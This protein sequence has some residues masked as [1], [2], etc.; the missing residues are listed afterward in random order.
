MS[1]ISGSFVQDFATRVPTVDVASALSPLANRIPGSQASGSSQ[2]APILT[3]APRAQKS[4]Q[5]KYTGYMAELANQYDERIVNA[6]VS[7]DSQRVSQGQNPLSEE[8]T[9]RALQTAQTG[10]AATQEASPSPFNL[11]GNAIRNIGDIVRSIPRIPSALVGEARDLSKIGESIEAGKNPISG[12]ASAP[13][14]RMLPGAYLVENLAE[15]DI[16]ELVSNPIFTALDVLPMGSQLAKSTKVATAAREGAQAVARGGESA[17]RVVGKTAG[18]EARRLA[19]MERRPLA[20]AL[21]N[22]LDADGNIVRTASGNVVDAITQSRMVRPLEKWFSQTQRD[23]M[24]EVNAAQQRVHNIVTGVQQAGDLG[25]PSGQLDSISRDAAKL[26]EDIIALDPTI[27][28]RIPEITQKMVEGK[29]NELTGI[30]AQAAQLYKSVM[31][32]TTE[33]SVANNYHVMFDG[34]VYDINSGLPLIKQ[35]RRMERTQRLNDLRNQTI[36][37]SANPADALKLLRETYA[38]ERMTPTAIGDDTIAK[39]TRAQQQTRAA[40]GNVVSGGELLGTRR[41]TLRALESSGYDTSAFYDV[42]KNSKGRPTKKMKADD[43]LIRVVDDVIEGRVTLEKK[44]LLNRDEILQV[45]SANEGTYK[46]NAL[47][48]LKAGLEKGEYKVVT[49]A[50]ETLKKQKGSAALSDPVFLDSIRQLRDTQREL[51]KTRR[52]YSDEAVAK[53]SKNLAEKQSVTPSARF[54]PE[55]DKRTRATVTEQLVD[56]LGANQRLIPG[57]DVL[58]AAQVIELADRGMWS[59]IPGWT[60]EM[61]RKIQREQVATWQDMKARGFDPMFIHTVPSNRIGRVLHPGESIVPN[62]PSST[63]AR[64]WDLAP[65]FKDFTIAATDQMIEYLRRRETEVAIKHVT[66]MVGESEASLRSRYAPLAE[67]RA[68]RATVKSFEQHMQDIIGEKHVKFDPESMGYNWGSPYLNQLSTE[69]MMV[70]KNVAENLKDLS[71]PKQIAGGLFDPATKTFRIAVVGLSLRTQIYNIVGGAVSNELRNPGSMLRQMDKVQDY[72]RAAD[73]P[74]VRKGTGDFSM[75]P[76]E[77]QEIIGSQKATIMELDDLSQGKVRRKALEVVSQYTKGKKMREM[78]DAEQAAKT[79]GQPS[80]MSKMG[81]GFQRAAQTMYD[82]NGLFDDAYRVVS[83]WDEFEKASKKGATTEVAAAKAVGE[84]RKVLQDWMGM[85]PME[86][87]VMKSLIPFYGFMSHA[88]RF[89]MQYPLDH[90]LRAEIMSKLAQA[91]MEDMDGLPKRF[92]SS[93][94]FGEQDASG[95]QNAFNLAP[96]NPFGD[97]ANLMTIQGFLGSTNPMITTAFQMAGLDQG[98]AE[99]YPSLRYDAETGRLSAKSRNPLMAMLDNT[100]PQSGIVTAMLGMNDQFNETLQ[101]D[102]AAANRFFLSSMTVP[103]L[104]REYSIPQEQFKAEVARYESQETVKNEALR[105]GDW[106]E[107]LRYPNL[108]QYLAALDAIPPEELSAFQRQTRD[109]VRTLA[110]DSL[111]GRGAVLPT[112][113]SL[114]D[115]IAETMRAQ[116]DQV[117]SGSGFTPRAMLSSGVRGAQPP[118]GSLS[119][120]S[121][122]NI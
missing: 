86:R 7:Y 95:K 97:V 54:L 105:S 50:L 57:D 99:L 89:V 67:M 17:T 72:I 10:E 80:K 122:G 43:D 118:A 34:E 32:R 120:T 25:T 15:G 3:N 51:A 113:G 114:D 36:N 104:W 73:I 77:L 108:A 121:A 6:M 48:I 115:Y 110:N 1:D 107:A 92:L 74:G 59:E 117:G 16:A 55:I 109:E 84:T 5:N 31:D 38:R 22:T 102:P 9:R 112:S 39:A 14:V 12:L 96:M 56:G 58:S 64:Q 11:F 4:L 75:F 44:Q 94:F 62:K 63:K 103:I 2:R 35:Q 19:Q 91:E 41:M 24:Y 81:D 13:G 70:P 29:W 116:V 69:G 106:S 85:T 45:I 26:R 30:D 71:K 79:P 42:G 60:K 33:W 8:A 82:F 23:V 53:A 98:E 88:V 47:A 90:P 61:H 78:F 119:N 37:G 49:K 101:R 66:D 111:A 76:Q 28:A 93:L 18:A 40:Q 27:E 68:E 83:Y 20:A 87:G 100:V 21:N 46:G 65:G 52:A